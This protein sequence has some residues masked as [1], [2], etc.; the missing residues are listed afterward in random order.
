[1]KLNTPSHQTCPF[2]HAPVALARY[3]YA[4]DGEHTWRI[5]PECD[6]TMLMTDEAAGAGACAVRVAPVAADRDVHD[7][8]LV[9]EPLHA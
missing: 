2:C 9:A 8:A 6:H 1:M 5:C 3:E 4:S 7:D